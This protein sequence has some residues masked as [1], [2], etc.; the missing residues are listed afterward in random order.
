MK[1]LGGFAADGMFGKDFMIM[2]LETLGAN[3]PS[4]NIEI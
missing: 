4:I 3:K 1:G 2:S